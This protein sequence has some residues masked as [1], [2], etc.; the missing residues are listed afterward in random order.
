MMN[1]K[2]HI[3]L[4][5]SNRGQINMVVCV[6]GDSFFF[7]P[8]V[9]NSIK[10][11]ANVRMEFLHVSMEFHLQLLFRDYS[12]SPKVISKQCLAQMVHH[13]VS[14]NLSYDVP[15]HLTSLQW[16]CMATHCA[17]NLTTIFQMLPPSHPLSNVHVHLGH[18]YGLMSLWAEDYSY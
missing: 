5:L 6:R 4:F 2:K 3:Y 11:R 8:T 15:L 14:N 12:N 9:I 18:I 1:K 13:L 17:A 7:L 10:K 16:R